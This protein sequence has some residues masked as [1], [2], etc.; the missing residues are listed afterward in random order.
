MPVEQADEH[1]IFDIGGN[2]VTSFAAPSRGALEAA[3]FRIDLP[4]GG[5]LPPH[6]HDHYDVFAVTRGGGAFHLEGDVRDLTVD[7][8]AVVPPG[9]LHWFEAGAEGAAIVVTM[10]PGTKMIREDDGT[11]TVPPWVA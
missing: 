10:L 6:R 5:G 1:P 2:T 9:S 3:L 7:D 4:A 8:S 11:E